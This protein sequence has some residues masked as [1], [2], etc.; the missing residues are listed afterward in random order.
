[1]ATHTHTQIRRHT[2]NTRSLAVRIKIYGLNRI[3][4]LIY[5]TDKMRCTNKIQIRTR[6]Q[7]RTYCTLYINTRIYRLQKW[8][9]KW[10]EISGWKKMHGLVHDAYTYVLFQK[11]ERFPKWPQFRIQWNE[12]HGSRHIYQKLKETHTAEK[13]RAKRTHIGQMKRYALKCAIEFVVFSFL[14][15]SLWP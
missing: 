13:K 9:I 8:Q 14:E 4:R 10:I 15:T 1:M 11:R 2:F 7:T 3:F 5:V 12:L 6:T